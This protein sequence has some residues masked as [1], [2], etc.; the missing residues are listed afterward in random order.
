[1]ACQL[2]TENDISALYTIV[3]GEIM[4]RIQDPKLGKFDNKTL[5]K[6]IKEIYEEFKDEPNGLLYAQAVPDILD[7]VKN[8][9]EIKKYLVKESGPTFFN[10]IQELSL[11]FEDE[12]NV[13][14]FVSTK[15][16]QPT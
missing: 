4:D 10:Y 12:N 1:M 2:Y 3:H 5:D 8:D 13:L 7:L 9:L 11:D 6:F 16:N 15:F 14:K